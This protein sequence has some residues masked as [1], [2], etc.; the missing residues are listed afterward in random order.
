MESNSSSDIT[1]RRALFFESGCLSIAPTGSRV[2]EGLRDIWA[3]VAAALRSTRRIRA[4]ASRPSQPANVLR[5]QVRPAYLRYFSEE[6]C[7][8]S[9]VRKGGL[10]PLFFSTL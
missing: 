2:D 10:P 8:H 4:G 6:P 9:Q 1:S 5:L 3:K 7:E